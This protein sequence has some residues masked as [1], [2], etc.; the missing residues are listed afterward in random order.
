[1]SVIT[2]RSGKQCQG[3]QSVASSSFANE[4]AQPHSTP[5]KDDDKKLKSKLPNNFYAG[6]S[7]EK[8]HIPFPFPPRAISNKKWKRQRRRSW[9]HLGK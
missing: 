4:P 6:D 9:K 8:Q 2:L 5:E 1:M 3:P 7:K